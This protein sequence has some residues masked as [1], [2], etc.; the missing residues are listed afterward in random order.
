MGLFSEM[1]KITDSLYLTGIGGMTQENMQRNRI[2][3]VINISHQEELK[4]EEGVE[5]LK[6]NAFDDETTNISCYFDTAAD[7]IDEVERKGGATVVHCM[8]GVSRSSTL[9]LAYLIKYKRMSLKDAF[10]FAHQRRN[11]IR[12]NNGFFTQLI[13]Y[14]KR[15][16][17]KTTAKM[18][19]VKR[20]KVEVEIPDFFEN[21][22]KKLVLLEILRKVPR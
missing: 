12:P 2:K 11:V 3:C 22:Y 9:V 6:F 20:G 21:E 7:K 18:I 14:E 13:A 17:G 1:S 8:C 4:T 15:I 5:Y 19:K 10:R 16:T